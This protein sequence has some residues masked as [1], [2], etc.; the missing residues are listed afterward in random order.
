MIRPL[1]VALLIVAAGCEPEPPRPRLSWQFVDERPCD[2]AGVVEVVAIDGAS[3]RRLGR[4]H[5]RDGL[6]PA[7]VELGQ[8]PTTTAITLEGRSIT[9]GLL[10]GAS[11]ELSG[12][13]EEMITLRFLG[14][15]SDS[16]TTEQRPKK[17]PPALASGSLGH[18]GEEVR[19][20]PFATS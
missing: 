19:R 11:V 14:G 15:R 3:E 9:G 17:E 12:A 10:Y 20:K 13:E 1:A 2:L 6:S 16:S 7:S 18:P 8:R 4:F 5:C